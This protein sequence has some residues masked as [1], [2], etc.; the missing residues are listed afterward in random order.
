M[1]YRGI[2]YDVGLHFE[3]G[4]LS[5]EPFSPT[6]VAHDMKTI[7]HSLHAKAVR[8]EGE[9]I[10]RLVTASQAAHAQGLTVFFNPWKMNA[11][12]EET[13]AYVKEAAIAAEQLRTSG[14]DIVLVAGCEYTI[15][16]KGVFPGDTFNERVTW[17]GEQLTSTK[18]ADM[19]QNL[20]ISIRE[21]SDKLNQVLHTLVET[22]RPIF[23]G[24]VTYSAG[25][26]E[27]VDWSIFDMIGIDYYRRDETEQ[28]Y[29]SGLDHH[30]VAGKPLIVMELGCC[31]YEGA[32]KRGDGGF[33]L[34]KG[35]NPDGTGIFQDDVVPTRSEREQADY[36]STQLGLLEKGGV[37]GAFAFVFSF[38]CM[39]I[40]EGAKDMDMMSFSLV[41]TFPKSDER[42]SAMPPWKEKEAFWRVAEIFGSAENSG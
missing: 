25:T 13:C 7:A 3:E 20:P 37:D 11:T 33:V 27:G 34:L 29:L 35:T 36:M 6:L 23:H 16:S 5:I 40:G 26:W 32:A 21:K 31:A 12:V 9:P 15:F 18:G 39:P 17:L 24:T 28:A 22:I 8:I 42:A 41:K 30:R 4:K 1:R 2:V 19:H 38:P 14:T 10:Y